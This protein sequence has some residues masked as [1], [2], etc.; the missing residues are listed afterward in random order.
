MGAKAKGGM[1][2]PSSWRHWKN[3]KKVLEK[4]EEEKRILS[5]KK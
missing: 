2:P 3:I 1:F 5:K 4:I